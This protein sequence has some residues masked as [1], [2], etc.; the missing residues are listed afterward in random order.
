MPNIRKV[1]LEI[2]VGKEKEGLYFDLPFEVPEEVERIDITYSYTRFPTL[3]SDGSVKTGE[4]NIIDLALSSN[5]GEFIG[6]S[7]SDRDHIWLSEYDV[8]DG[9]APVEIGAGTWNII[10]GAYKVQVAGVKVTYEVTF[11]FKERMLLKGD[12]HLH[13]KGS[14]GILSVEEVAGFAKTNGLDFL[15]ITD[16]NNYAHNR[17]LKSNKDLTLIPG[18]EWTHFEGHANM[19]GV[20]RPFSG[21]YYANN[22]DEVREKLAEARQKG[23]LVSINHPFD[24][25]CPWKWGLDNIEFDCVEIWNSIIKASDMKCIAWWHQELCKGRRLPAIGGSD[26]HR[27]H[28]FGMPGMPTTCVYSM[29]RGQTDILDA[30]KKGHAYITFQADAPQADIRCRGNFMGDEIPFEQNL[31]I[32]FEFTSVNAGDAIKIIS[33]SGVE[34]EF[35]VERSGA[36]SFEIKAENKRFYRAELYRQLLP[37]LPPMLY[38]ITNPLYFC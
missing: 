3:S 36:V 22:L 24:A 8:S 26:F 4:V 11:T 38:L 17:G 27:F 18:T 6:S 9:Y 15:F 16:H 13:T 30:I 7:G 34:K 28:N 2:L 20:E 1:Q 21:H 32:I 33:A 19:L 31:S 37:G 35:V 12:C 25:G 5:T 10:V 29:S 14:D 23:A